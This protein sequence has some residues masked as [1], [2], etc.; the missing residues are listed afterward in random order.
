MEKRL[1]HR[2]KWESKPA[3]L[4]T[5]ACHFHRWQCVPCSQVPFAMCDSMRG[6]GLPASG[7]LGSVLP[8]FAIYKANSEPHRSATFVRF[9]VKNWTHKATT[10]I[11]PQTTGSQKAIW[12]PG[13][14]PQREAGTL[15]Y[16]VPHGQS[17]L[18]LC[19]TKP[20]SQGL[21]QHCLNDLFDIWHRS[22]KKK[23]VDTF[24]PSKI[25]DLQRWKFLREHTWQQGPP[26]RFP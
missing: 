26:G 3:H 18:T 8:D 9:A 6:A 12:S 10:L 25:Q 4:P 7:C 17:Y 21:F 24:P 16:F 2:C 22:K 13:S 23:S 1:E 15:S 11:Q 20:G 5:Q 19:A 14:S